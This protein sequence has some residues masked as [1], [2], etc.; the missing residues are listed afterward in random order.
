MDSGGGWDLGGFS[1]QLSETWNEAGAL[2]A[3]SPWHFSDPG[4]QR[5]CYAMQRSNPITEQQDGSSGTVGSCTLG[6]ESLT[7]NTGHSLADFMSG[8]ETFMKGPFCATS[9]EPEPSLYEHFLPIAVK[10]TTG[11]LEWAL[12]V[13]ETAGGN[14]SH[15]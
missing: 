8:K 14:S 7:G 10:V 2:V 3:S 1:S 5:C 15:R 6:Y 9:F 4:K 12:L 11:F 13:S